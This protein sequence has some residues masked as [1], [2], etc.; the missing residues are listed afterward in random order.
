MLSRIGLLLLERGQALAL[1]LL[2]LGRGGNAGSRSAS[3]VRRSSVGQMRAHGLAA[4]R[5]LGLAAADRKLRAEPVERVLERLPVALLRAERQHRAARPPRGDMP[6]SD[7]SSPWCRRS[8][9]CTVSPRVFFG[10]SATFMPFGSANRC[11]R[12]SRLAGV[13]SNDSPAATPGSPL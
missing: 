12:A 9:T 6:F 1:Q 7:V 8:W 10:S 11:V 3:A 2:E 5:G 13:G 4:R